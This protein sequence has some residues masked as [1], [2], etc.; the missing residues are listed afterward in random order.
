MFPTAV[1]LR[2]VIPEVPLMFSIPVELFVKPPV[3]ESAV[4]MFIVP[5]FVITAGL[6]IVI[7]VPTLSV[8]EI[9]YAVPV[10]ENARDE[11]ELLVEPPIVWFTPVKV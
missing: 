10:P 6:V 2:V 5:L 4:D 9:E 3:P 7:K 8:P 1:A 11:I